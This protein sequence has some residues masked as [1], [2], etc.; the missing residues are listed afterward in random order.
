MWPVLAEKAN[1]DQF[2]DLKTIIIGFHAKETI[3]NW[4]SHLQS[5]A[6]NDQADYEAVQNCTILHFAFITEDQKSKIDNTSEW[7]LADQRMLDDL[8]TFVINIQPFHTKEI[9][10]SRA[11]NYMYPMSRSSIKNWIGSMKA[12]CAQCK[13]CK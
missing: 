2:N 5:G 12:L 10:F 1:Q 6:P 4:F 3:R 8:G 7:H 9:F 13:L 11:S